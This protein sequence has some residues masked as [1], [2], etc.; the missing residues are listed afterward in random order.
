MEQALT[1]C[2]SLYGQEM[3]PQIDCTY[4]CYMPFIFHKTIP[5]YFLIVFKI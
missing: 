5:N 3:K 1:N 4:T 2:N